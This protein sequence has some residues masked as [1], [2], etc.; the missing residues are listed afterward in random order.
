MS[1]IKHTRTILKVIYYFNFLLFTFLAL[2][3]LSIKGILGKSVTPDDFMWERMGI[4][5]MLLCIPVALKTFYILLNKKNHL[6]Q[7]EY[8]S[9]LKKLYIARLLLIDIAIIVNLVCFY[10]IGA[11]NFMYLVSIGILSFLMCY[12]VKSIFYPVKDIDDSLE[13]NEINN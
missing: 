5:V 13:E 12:P 6:P 4:I 9:S 8:I 11:L 1:I 2:Y 3:L 10:T 7:K